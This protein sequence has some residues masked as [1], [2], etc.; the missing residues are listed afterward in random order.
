MPSPSSAQNDKVT[1]AFNFDVKLLGLNVQLGFFAAVTGFSS[2]VD[3]LEYPEGGQNTFVH[4][5]PT[6]VKQGNITLKRGVVT[7]EKAL[8]DWYQKTVVQVQPV[9]LQISL[10]NT[11]LQP[12]RVWNFANAYPVKWTSI[13]LTAASTEIV[14]EQLEVA[15]TGMT[16][17]AV[18]S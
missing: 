9:T 11:S 3:V 18:G 13:D 14:T 5:L 7:S 8:L 16:V 10:M 6:R 4:R 2:Q 17:Q 15:H 1:Q 12:V